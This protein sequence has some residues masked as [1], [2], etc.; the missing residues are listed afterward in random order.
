VAVLEDPKNVVRAYAHGNETNTP[1][2]T[3]NLQRGGQVIAK[4]VETISKTL[5]ETAHNHGLHA[6][7]A[8]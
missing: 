3:L 1:E 7:H 2:E 4:P 8:L 5:N 6:R